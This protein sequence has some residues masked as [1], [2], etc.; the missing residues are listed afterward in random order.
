MIFLKKN[1][2]LILFILLLLLS[3]FIL[4]FSEEISNSNIES[5]EN[6]DQDKKEDENSKNCN[7][8]TKILQ[9]TSN[10]S[11]VKTH[12]IV[13]N[14]IHKSKLQSCLFPISHEEQIKQLTIKEKKNNALN[15]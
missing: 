2:N 6:K 5:L 15:K 4:I 14:S 9:S 8:P 3:I 11:H 10:N 12:N 7:K 1:I 13:Q